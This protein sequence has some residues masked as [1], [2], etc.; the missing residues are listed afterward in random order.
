MTSRLSGILCL[1]SFQQQLTSMAKRIQHLPVMQEV[2]SSIPSW[3]LFF[4]VVI[5]DVFYFLVSERSGK[6]V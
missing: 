6:P 2:E 5:L 1:L 3:L 4:V